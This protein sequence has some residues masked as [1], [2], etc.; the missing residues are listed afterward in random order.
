MLENTVFEFKSN[1]C[2]NI[3]GKN[4]FSP[5]KSEN[6]ADDAKVPPPDPKVMFMY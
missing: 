1:V 5:K 6:D 4:N 3:V 2:T